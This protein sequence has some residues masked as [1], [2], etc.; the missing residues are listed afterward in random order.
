MNAGRFGDLA[1]SGIWRLNSAQVYSLR[2]GGVPLTGV[3]TALLKAYPDAPASQTVYFGERGSQDFAG[4]GLFD[5]SVNYDVPVF[6]TLRPWVK[7]DVF[8]LFDNQKLIRWDTT[9]TPDPNSPVDSLGLPTGYLKGPRF[10]TAVSNS[11]YP[12]AIQGIAGGRMLRLAV[13]FRF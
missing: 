5:L 7:M 10:G 3:Q 8:N 4:Y 2:A 1:F 6:K 12:Q 13:G 11:S 9:V